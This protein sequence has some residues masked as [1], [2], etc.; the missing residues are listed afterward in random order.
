MARRDAATDDTTTVTALP[1]ARAATD[2]R[3]V[4]PPE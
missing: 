3:L 2:W 4:K 1:T